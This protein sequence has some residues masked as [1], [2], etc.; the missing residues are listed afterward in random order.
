MFI[1]P[2][3]H[4]RT[5]VICNSFFNTKM[6]GLIYSFIF[7]N[8]KLYSY[9]NLV[10]AEHNLKNLSRKIII[11]TLFNTKMKRENHLTRTNVN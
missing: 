4:A 5:P 9:L 8:K 3:K 11:K 10:L 6:I 2:S 7:I 1:Y